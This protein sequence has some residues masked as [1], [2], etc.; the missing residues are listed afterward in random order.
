MSFNMAMLLASAFYLILVAGFFFMR[1]R[2]INGETKIYSYLLISDAILI[3]F[4]FLCVLSATYDKSGSTIYAMIVGRGLLVAILFWMTIFT[5]YIILI[6]KREKPDNIFLNHKL[7]F[8]G[9]T[10]INIIGVLFLPLY[11][12]SDGVVAYTYG[13]STTYLVMLIFVAVTINIYCAIKSRKYLEKKKILPI[14]AFI[15][16]IIVLILIRSVAPQV[17]MFSAIFTFITILMYFTIENPDVKMIERLSKAKELY[18]KSNNEKSNFIY[19]VSDDINN[20]LDNADII[21]DKVMGLEPND[22][23]KNYMTDLKEVITGARNMLKQTIDLSDIDNKHLQLTNNKYNTKN[24]LNSVF[25]S[26]K[27]NVKDGVDYRINLAD[28][29]PEE[30]YGDSIKVKQIISS[31]LSNSIKYTNKGFIELRVNS[32]IKSKICRLIITIEDSG[33]GMDLIKQNEIM[34]NHDDL[35]ESDIASL[36]KN[37]VNLKVVRKMVSLIGGIFLI[38]NNKYGGTTISISLDQRVVENMLSNEEE[39]LMEYSNI[40]NSQKRC[41]IISLDKKDIKSLKGLVKKK[42]FI[43]NEFNVTKNLLDEVRSNVHYDLIIIDENMEKIDA[44]SL[45]FKLKKENIFKGK[46]IVVS[47]NKDLKVKKELLEL[48]FSSVIIKPID[49]KE[50][51]VCLDNL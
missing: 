24:L 4:E 8:M 17:Q 39:K 14:I 38:D 48:G 9:I 13:A 33:I 45:L 32:I 18:E 23:I 1:K 15:T 49:K 12:Y 26:V 31:V 43:V 19:V 10:T 46:V 37:D 21:Y 7:L 50:V 40:I 20:R 42:G 41:A 51:I 2:I 16:S 25:S 44:R 3:F 11:F 35:N 6:T 5:L 22:E 30:L 27:K 29:L 34:N 47:K 36:D 28:D